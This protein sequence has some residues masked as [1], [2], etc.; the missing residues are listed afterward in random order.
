MIF[1]WG[2]GG[3]YGVFSN[4]YPCSFT[5][6]KGIKYNCTEQY[7]MVQ[8]LLTFDPSNHD[9]LSRMLSETDPKSIKKYGRQVKNYNETTWNSIRYQVMLQGVILKFTQNENLLKILIGTGSEILAEASPYD[10]IWGI[11][12]YES[13]AKNMDPSQWKG[14]NLLGKVLMEVRRGFYT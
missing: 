12:M 11:G 1:F 7:F 8:K 5:D 2:T 13:V 10:N 9:L 6:D 14:Q 4:F 3:K